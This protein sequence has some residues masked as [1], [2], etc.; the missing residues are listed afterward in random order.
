MCSVGVIGFLKNIL[1]VKIFTQVTSIIIVKDRKDY[2]YEK[3]FM[4]KGR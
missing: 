1:A 3:S 4:Q 2:P